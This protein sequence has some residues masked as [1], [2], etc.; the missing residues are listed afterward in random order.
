[1]FYGDAKLRTFGRTDK[2]LQFSHLM[3]R[4][5]HLKP[6]FVGKSLC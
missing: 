4:T 6:H 1:M 5:I 3:Y 2:D